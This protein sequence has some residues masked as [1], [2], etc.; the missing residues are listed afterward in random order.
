[1]KTG[2]ELAREIERIGRRVLP[3]QMDM[4]QLDQ[5][6]RAANDTA[7]HFGRLDIL[8]NS[9]GLYPENIPP[10]LQRLP[11]SCPLTRQVVSPPLTQAVD[12]RRGLKVNERNRDFNAN[13]K[14]DSV[15]AGSC[16]ENFTVCTAW[17]GMYIAAA[18][19]NLKR[20][21]RHA[22]ARRPVRGRTFI[23]R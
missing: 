3:L 4:T 2:G 21:A 7:A 19:L 17:K 23:V 5:I 15:T 13:F 8:V 12:A 14:S 11:T 10:A 20:R 6:S 18:F 16:C 9:A 22:S 1:M